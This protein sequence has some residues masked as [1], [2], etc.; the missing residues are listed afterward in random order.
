M[1]SPH[2]MM[3]EMEMLPEM[4]DRGEASELPAPQRFAASVDQAASAAVMPSPNIVPGRAVDV[5]AENPCAKY[6]MPIMITVEPTSANSSGGLPSTK[7]GS[8]NAAST[9]KVPTSPMSARS[10]RQR[11]TAITTT[12]YRVASSKIGTVRTKMYGGIAW[13]AAAPGDD[14]KS[15]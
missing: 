6:S 7:P 4:L 13:L 2:R 9:A 3:S 1:M 12:E 14:V 8:T 15:K 11:A 10:P 5:R